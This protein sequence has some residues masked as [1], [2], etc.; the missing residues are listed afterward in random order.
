[1]CHKLNTKEKMKLNFYLLLIISLIANYTFSQNAEITGVVTDETGIS[2]PTVLVYLNESPTPVRT[3]LD[4][5]FKFKN[6]HA[7]KHSLTFKFSDYKTQTI[8][9]IQI[10]NSERKE[11]NVKMEPFVQEIEAVVVTA[12]IDKGGNTSLEKEKQN[13]A[14]VSDGASSE[15]IKKRPD[16]KASDALK[17]ISGASIQDNKFVIIR[18]LNDRY[19]AAYINGAPLPSSESDRKA[20]SFD[21]FPAIMLDNIVINKTATP[22]MPAE[23]AGGVININTKNPKDTNFQTLSIGT[24][25]NTLST[26]KNFKTYDGGKTDWM[27]IDDGSRALSKNIPDTKEFGSLNTSEKARLAQNVTPS[28]AI[29]NRMALPG[30]NLQYAMN[31]NIKLKDKNLGVVFAYTYQNNFNTNENIRREFEEQAT[32]VVLKSV[33][34]DSVYSQTVLNSGLLNFSFDI[35]PS[36]KLRFKNMFSVNSEDKVNIRKGVREMD[37]DPHIYEKSSNRQ[38]TQNVLYSSQ[39]EGNHEI[40]P[41]KLKFN[42]NLG[43]SDV[44][45]SVP[46]M[47]RIVYQKTAMDEADTSAKYIAVVQNNGTIP[48][49]AGNMFWSETKERI[50]SAKYD[51]IIPFDR[52]NVKT[53]F[54]IGGMQ[55]FRSRTF[56]ARN[57]GFSRFKGNGINF[58]NE[59]L[60][61]PENEIFAPAHLGVMENGLGGFKLE[62]ATKVSDSYSA[63][64]M[65]HAGF[66]MFDTKIK[67]KFR[68]VGGARLESYQQKFAYTEFGSNI[69][70]KIDTTVVDILPSINFIY[71]LTKKMNI[72][73]SYYKTLSRPEF[74]ELAPFAFYN[75]AMD[76]ILSGNTTLKRAL[77]DNMDV[78][79]ELFPG[80]GQIFSISGF[81]KKFTNPIE[82][83]NRTGTSGASELYYTNVPKVV[84]YGVELEY[85]VKLS[86]IFNKK[87]ENILLNSTTLFTNLALIKSKV[88]VSNINGSTGN[89]RPLQGQSPYIINAG[90]QFTNPANDLSV[91]ISYNVVGR[92]IYIVGNVQEPDVWENHRQVVDLQIAKTFLH[93]KM[94][95]KLNVRDLLAQK[96]V[97][98]Q[99]LNHNKKYDKS[100]DNRWQETSFGQTISLSASYTF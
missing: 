98:Y 68:F 83:V 35:N 50:Y 100:T 53:E 40:I 59:L 97:F 13:S 44:N 17:R 96:L 87:T 14:T 5:K 69:D 9:D 51:F 90:L 18:G 78:R 76:N 92:R 39:L 79:Y 12:T 38:F 62:E 26:F 84:N 63:S 54:K 80:A 91:S 86:T 31:R 21:I 66:V 34:K 32:G 48:T 30:L 1:M 37:S 64:S 71:S 33:L 57:L 43:I 24:S 99:D 19:N 11:L 60:L 74:R 23:F 6:L 2:F 73:L 46:N 27:G 16:T 42:W 89:S 15:D 36:N 61:L 10:N 47:R 77:I 67:E 8:N 3:D 28:W 65:L 70:K 7:G 4:G 49:A 22:D 81:Y 56:S 88:D 25:Y 52:K 85:R 75:F 93:K 45:R 41:S 82:L 95:I 29:K 20:F 94:E 72:R 55:Q 58:D